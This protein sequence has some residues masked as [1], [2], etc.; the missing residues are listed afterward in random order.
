MRRVV[1][2][3]TERLIG[4][5]VVLLLLSA[6]IAAAA[7]R[8]LRYADQ[9]APADVIVLFVGPGN[10]ERR[11]KALA[12][13]RAGYAD[14]LFI[15]AHRSI[16]SRAGAGDAE[17]FMIRTTDGASWLERNRTRR[18][19]THYEQ[20]HM[21]ILIARDFMAE[22]GLRSALFVS[23]PYHMRRIHLISGNVFSPDEVA[24]R[25]VSPLEDEER[26]P[27]AADGRGIKWVVSEYV[28]IAWF[29]A[30][31]ALDGALPAGRAS[32]I[33]AGNPMAALSG[34]SPREE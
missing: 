15:P 33:K 6:L 10:A 1:G 17:R 13:L 32:G 24:I 8:F 16:V 19:P 7:P 30:Y 29:L 11:A 18:F 2:C 25:F 5:A 14:T 4:T 22:R 9:P 21:E 34:S 12:L 20:T 28:K 23:S 3:F 31:R 27:L 26:H